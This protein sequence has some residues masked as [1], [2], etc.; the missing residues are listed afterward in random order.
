MGV[1]VHAAQ[2]NYLISPRYLQNHRFITCKVKE[3]VISSIS[4]LNSPLI[5]PLVQDSV[6][7][8]LTMVCQRSNISHLIDL[9]D[10]TKKLW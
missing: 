4:S 5:G 3:G 6:S 1:S 8:Q 9:C 10:S 2:N 7:K